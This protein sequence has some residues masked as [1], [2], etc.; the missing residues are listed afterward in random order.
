MAR[1]A[2]CRAWSTAITPH[3]MVANPGLLEASGA[4]GQASAGRDGMGGGRH[5]QD[6]QRLPRRPAAARDRGGAAGRPDRGGR[7]AACW[8]GTRSGCPRRRSLQKVCRS[9]PRPPPVP[10]RRS[11]GVADDRAVDRAVAGSVTPAPEALPGLAG[12]RTHAT[13]RD[14]RHG[15]APG[16]GGQGADVPPAS[17]GRPPARVPAVRSGHSP[18]SRSPLPG[19][20]GMVMWPTVGSGP[21]AAITR[22]W[23]TRWKIP[24]QAQAGVVCP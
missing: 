23:S 4:L 22:R 7:Y 16:Q 11:H 19:S 12:R 13:G 18:A 20:A 15:V 3:S 24:E 9:C 14:C 17:G 1:M 10:S 8:P 5:Q 21:H 6:D 2:R